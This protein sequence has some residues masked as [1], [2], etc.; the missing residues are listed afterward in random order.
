MESVNTMSHKKNYL[1]L[2][3][4]VLVACMAL[5]FL[6]KEVNHFSDILHHIPALMTYSVPT[7][8]ACFF[9]YKRFL[10]KNNK[11]ESLY[12]SLAL[13]LPLGIISII[14]ILLLL[15]RLFP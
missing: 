12:L 15:F 3:G 7:F 11:S 8:F 1:I 6:D 10:R 5:F 2:S 4:S 13:G 9:L 14:V